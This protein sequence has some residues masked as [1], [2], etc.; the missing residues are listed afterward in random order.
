M[1]KKICV[2]GEGITSLIV[3]R[4]LLDLNLEIDLVSESFFSS[5]KYDNRS[6]AIS[7]SNFEYLKNLKILDKKNH[8]WKI[9]EINLFNAKNNQN[10]SKI[11]DFKNRQNKPLFIMAGYKNLVL[12]LKEKIVKNSSLKIYSTKIAKK[13]IKDLTIHNIKSS[14]NYSLVINCNNSNIINNKFFNKKIKKSYFSVSFTSIINHKNIKNEIASQFFMNQGPMAFLPLSNSK[15]F[16]IWSVNEKHLSNKNKINYSLFKK[17]I[18]KN[19]ENN[20]QIISLSKINQFNL[21]FM[22]PREYYYENILSF[23]EALH[24]VHPLSGQGLNMIIRDIKL[25]NYII[26]KNMDL[27]LDLSVSVLKE[28]RDEVKSYNYLFSKSIDLT[29]KYFSIN[30]EIFNE[31]SNQCLK[32]INKNISLKNILIDIADKGINIQNW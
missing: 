8:T 29:E 15:T 1:Y 20:L 6:L 16:V 27:G 17:Q 28:F 7:Y 19:V 13:I 32:N 11:F 4:V 14:Y 31:I 30:N 12:D 10:I 2:I 25:L 24:Q 9:N 21:H 18:K 26:K 23:G 22:V 3:T 5:K